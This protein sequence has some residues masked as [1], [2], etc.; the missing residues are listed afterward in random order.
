MRVSA[1]ERS[2]DHWARTFIRP[3]AVMV[4]G[5]AIE[6]VFE[7]DDVQG[8]VVFYSKTGGRFD[9]SVDG[10]APAPSMAHGKVQIIGRKH[11]EGL[12]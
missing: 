4:D 12:N 10:C 1:D 9:L 3:P 6:G 8:W 5:K 7:A 11:G 2:E